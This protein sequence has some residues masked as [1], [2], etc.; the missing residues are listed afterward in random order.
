MSMRRKSRKAAQRNLTAGSCKRL[1]LYYPRSLR[2]EP[3]EDRRLLAVL[4]VTTTADTTDANDGLTSLREAIVATNALSG[5][6]TINFDPALTAN[7]PA[8]IVVNPANLRIT[9]ALAIN[10]PGANLLTIR[11]NKGGQIFNI[12]DASAN[13]LDVSLSG[14]TLTGATNS[15]ISTSENLTVTDCVLSGNSSTFAG[16]AIYSRGTSAAPNSLTIVGCTISN[17]KSNNSEGG[18]IRQQYGSLTIEDSTLDGNS[19]KSAGGAI[20]A[21]DGGIVVTIQGSTI[22]NNLASTNYGGGVFVKNGD[23]T[24][25]DSTISG[26]SAPSGGGI[27]SQLFNSSYTLSLTDTVVSNNYGRD[28]GGGLDS[29]GPVVI[30]RCT[31]SNNSTRIGTGLLTSGFAGGILATQLTMT[32]SSVFGNKAGEIGG[33]SCTNAEITNSTLSGNTATFLAGAL[34][35]RGGIVKIRYSTITDNT[36]PLASPGAVVTYGD[37]GT[38]TEIGSSIVAGNVNGDVA[39]TKT[40]NTFVSLGYNLIDTGN[41]VPNFNQPGD[42]TGVLDPMLGPL[43]DNGGPT[44][45][46]AL[47]AGSPA[48]NAGDPNSVA[49]INGV[50]FR[51]QR[52]A[53]FIRVYGG[54]IDIGAFELQPTDYVLGDFNR[55]GAVDAADYAILRKQ[56]GL[57]VTPGSGADANGDGLVNDADTMVWRANYGQTLP[58]LPPAPALAPAAGL[59]EQMATLPPAQSATLSPTSIGSRPSSLD[60]SP[61]LVSLP[62]DKQDPLRSSKGVWQASSNLFTSVER[63][64]R[65]DYAIEAWLA[66]TAGTEKRQLFE[67]TSERSHLADCEDNAAEPPSTLGPAVDAV[68]TTL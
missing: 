23:M 46:H 8:T 51:D 63:A 7:G 30:T 61:P 45:T 33:I 55:D 16:G 53:P 47:L 48:I 54:R 35:S 5:A 20:S 6:D 38:V 2:Y 4:T 49:G 15:A 40:T 13:L 24:V 44:L 26:N 36:S 1:S 68:F 14:L 32:D 17:N 59:N 65:F 60:K 67:S 50:P 37:A 31:F 39:F 19:A 22:N 43:A 52:G 62:S 12:S 3:L 21:A 25:N 27:E 57:T 10:G 42:Q 18:A 56:M 34:F 11:P 64:S 28:D 41:A 66:S 29:F 58:P 9:D